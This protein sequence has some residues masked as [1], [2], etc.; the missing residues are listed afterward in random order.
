MRKLINWIF[1]DILK[2]LREINRKLDLLVEARRPSVTV[3]P[4]RK[5]DLPFQIQMGLG[6]FTPLA[7][8]QPITGNIDM[9]KTGGKQ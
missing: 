2:E 4:I 3:Q 8:L 5:E 7:P 1:S 6:S 9:S